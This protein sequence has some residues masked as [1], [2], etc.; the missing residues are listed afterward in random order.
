MTSEPRRRLT[1]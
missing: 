1:S